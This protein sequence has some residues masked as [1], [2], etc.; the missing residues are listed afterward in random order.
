[1]LAQGATEYGFFEEIWACE[2]MAQVT[3]WE[4]RVR[5]HNGHVVRLLKDLS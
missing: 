4:F 1:L 3:A 2:R 5:R